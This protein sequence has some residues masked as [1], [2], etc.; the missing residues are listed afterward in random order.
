MNYYARYEILM[1]VTRKVN[2][3]FTFVYLLIYV[4]I[5]TKSLEILLDIEKV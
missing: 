5:D 2:V 4:H 1:A 3:F